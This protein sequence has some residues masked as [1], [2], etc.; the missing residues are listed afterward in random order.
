[1]GK[2]VALSD[3]IL[4]LVKFRIRG[5]LRFL[6][7]AETLVMF[8]RALTRADIPVEYSQGF[9]PHQ[10]VSLPLPRSVGLEVDADM[11]CAKIKAK[12]FDAQDF[13]TRLSSQL[14]Q[15]CEILNVTV[16]AAGVMPQP[17]EA[18]YILE[19]AKDYF[20]E[21]LVKKIES[22]LARDSISLQRQVDEKGRTRNVDVRPYLAAISAEDSLITVRC[23]ISPA[24]SVRVNEILELLDLDATKLASPVRRTN[25]K[26]EKN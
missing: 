18:T 5:N 2:I 14:P 3:K 22:L 13:K 19:V 20:D 26:W 7:H 23:N 17:A 24:G 8:Q 6:S 10:R 11:L 16:A 1:M 12:G 15:G 21:G 25:I 4:V 9:N